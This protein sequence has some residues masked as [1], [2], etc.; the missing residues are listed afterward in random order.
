MES[1]KPETKCFILVDSVEEI[2][3]AVTYEEYGV[4]NLNNSPISKVQRGSIL[5]LYVLGPINGIVGFGTVKNKV[6]SNNVLHKVE[7][8]RNYCLPFFLWKQQKISFNS[9]D[10]N[11]GIY[12]LDNSEEIVRISNLISLKWGTQ[13]KGSIESDISKRILF[14]KNKCSECGKEIDSRIAK[15]CADC[16]TKV[17]K[18]QSEEWNKRNIHKIREAGKRWRKNNPEKVREY[19]LRWKKEHPNKVR[20][21]RKR[22]KEKHPD[23][24]KESI[25]RW[26]EKKKTITLFKE[27]KA[28]DWCRQLRKDRAHLFWM[29]CHSKRKEKIAGIERRFNCCWEDKFKEI[30]EKYSYNDATKI[31]NINPGTLFTWAKHL[32]LSKKNIYLQKQFKFNKENSYAEKRNKH[33]FVQKK[34]DI[35]ELLAKID[36]KMNVN[37]LDF[38]NNDVIQSLRDVASTLPTREY[39]VIQN[40]YLYSNEKKKTLEELGSE[41]GLT[42]ERIRQLEV[43]G[44]SRLSHP[45]RLKV[46]QDKLINT[47]FKRKE[48]LELSL[49][50]KMAKLQIEL[51][52]L[53][54][55][56]GTRPHL[57]KADKPLSEVELSVRASNCLR[58][59]GIST[60]GELADK[61]EEEILSIRYL[62]RKVL[63]ELRKVLS[64]FGLTFNSEYRFVD[65]QY[66]NERIKRTVK[67]KTSESKNRGKC[68]FDGCN[69]IPQ[70][71]KYC[72]K[73]KTSW[74]RKRASEML[75]NEKNVHKHMIEPLFAPFQ[76]KNSK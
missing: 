58:D 74:R 59:A 40:R 44:I 11:I 70:K 72:S 31:L 49:S 39:F 8:E 56:I 60:L 35:R 24:V 38:N 64:S 17:K 7:F 23:K 26:K 62:G 18:R 3:E 67:W 15:Y 21:L 45:S 12:C 52:R 68:L 63:W 41:L 4:K 37:A 14:Q 30:Y 47:I 54:K 43:K 2:K 34:L 22:W 32:G 53:R 1:L 29:S 46:I 13:L 69:V 16:S 57:E 25:Q 61:T 10:N 42:R 65:S 9:F 75:E 36:P 33:K 76:S 71:G 48:G 66:K 6:E 55:E 20:E 19:S 27:Q 5:L 73:H 50:N 28:S 51:D